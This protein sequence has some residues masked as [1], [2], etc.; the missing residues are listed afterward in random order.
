M[1]YSWT[2][3]SQTELKLTRSDGPTLWIPADKNNREYQEFL[4]SGATA[5]PYVAPTPTPP[6]T[7]E[8]KVDNLLSDYGLTRD[9][10][11]AA[12]NATEE[13]KEISTMPVPE[14]EVSTM[15]VP[16]E[17]DDNTTN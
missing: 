14:E 11:R 16:E 3:E 8:Q 17:N 4:K 2:N 1:N 10:M 9:E 15:P 12:L 7:T 13:E 5:A 6:L